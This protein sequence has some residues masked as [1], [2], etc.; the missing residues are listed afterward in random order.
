MHLTCIGALERVQ[1]VVL[2]PGRQTLSASAT[3]PLAHG[4]FNSCCAGMH[5]CRGRRDA[6]ERPAARRT[7]RCA[8]LVARE[9][10]PAPPGAGVR[11]CRRSPAPC[12]IHQTLA[13]LM[14]DAALCRCAIL[15]SRQSPGRTSRPPVRRFAA[16]PCG[17]RRLLKNEFFNNLLIQAAP[18][19]AGIP[20]FDDPP[21][22]RQVIYTTNAVESVNMRLRK[23]MKHRGSFPSDEALLKLFYL[24]L[25]N[26]SKKWTL[27]I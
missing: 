24:A 6:R 27:P 2:H 11:G 21:E 1:R 20:F 3:T 5:E 14:N 9:A 19:A 22:I 16:H 13:C 17:A 4:F 10:R 23:I 26:I 8:I 7:S 18:L 25:R 15:A 12:S